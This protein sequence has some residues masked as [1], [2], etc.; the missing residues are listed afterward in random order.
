[1]ILAPINSA[2][3]AAAYLRISR[4]FL[5]ALARRGKIGALKQGQAWTFPAEAI[6]A[7]VESNTR[8]ALPANPHGLTD[9]SLRRVKRK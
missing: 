4:P 1:M 9:S 2:D 3:E 6:E 7:Y 5:L 8:N